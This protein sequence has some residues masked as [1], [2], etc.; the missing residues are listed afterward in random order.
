MVL[1]ELRELLRSYGTAARELRATYFGSIASGPSEH[2]PAALSEAALAL[3][4][5]DDL[6]FDALRGWIMAVDQ[7]HDYFA[8]NKV[9]PAMARRTGF[10]APAALRFGLWFFLQQWQ[11]VKYEKGWLGLF[12][13]AQT[14]MMPVGF[15][16]AVLEEAR[17]VSSLSDATDVESGV[18]RVQ[19]M[20]GRTFWDRAATAELDRLL[21][22]F[23]PPSQGH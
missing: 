6:G 15:A 8:A 23:K 7:E 11:T 16:S 21:A 3:A 19:D 12:K 9:F 20:L 10:A 5:L 17:E 1:P 2:S 4:M 13:A 22:T 14:V 18:S